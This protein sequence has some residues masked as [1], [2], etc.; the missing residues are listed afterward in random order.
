MR[1]KL[2]EETADRKKKDLK[3][4]ED[5]KKEAELKNGTTNKN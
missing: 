3:A 4:A 5:R 1:K 2:E